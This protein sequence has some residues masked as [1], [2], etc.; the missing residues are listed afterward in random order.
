M[1]QLSKAVSIHPYFKIHE[2]RMD[3]FKSLINEFIKST[4]SEETCLYYDF[5]ICGDV[6]FCREAYVDGDAVLAHLENV[7]AHIEASGAFSDMIKLEMHGPA[8]EL[9]KLRGPLADLPVEYFV[10]V[11]G[12]QK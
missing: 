11:G 2:G 10:H 3:D 1:N 4:S 9:D 5:S 8:D 12:V 6:A 7:G